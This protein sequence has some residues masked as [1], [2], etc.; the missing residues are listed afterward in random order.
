M[1]IRSL[2][3]KN[4]L[5]REE[6]NTIL[7]KKGRKKMGK[8]YE[9][10]FRKLGKDT[11]IWTSSLDIILPING[12][13]IKDF[14]EWVNWSGWKGY[15]PYHTAYDFAAYLSKDGKV[16]LGL[17]EETQVRVIA[18]GIVR[19]VSYGLAGKSVPYGCFINVEHGRDG[20]GLFSSYHHIN[21]VV[22]H[23]QKVKKG[24][25]IGTL[26]KDK[27]EEG[28]LVHLHFELS[29]GW[30]TEDRICNPESIYSSITRYRAKPQ[31]SLDFRVYEMKFETTPIY[32]FSEMIILPEQPKIHIANFKKLLI[33]NRI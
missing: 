7:N 25:I 2:K 20:S 22:K 28:K 32:E 8:I 21:P 30:N 3:I 12:S 26:H 31:S 33:N 18:D 27:G 4:K 9:K 14:E 19:Q 24:D 29:H 11:E 6:N 1:K 13:D 10:N 5:Q 23:N 15:S 16:V 17:N